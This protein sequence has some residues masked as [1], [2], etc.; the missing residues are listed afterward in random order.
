M[1]VAD[2]VNGAARRLRARQHLSVANAVLDT[3]AIVPTEDRLVIF[4][5]I[6]TAVLLPYLVAVKSLY[7]QIGRGRIILLDDG[8][9]TADDKTILAHHCGNPH[10]VS[11][12]DVSTA[13]CP[14]G[15]CWER[16]LAILDQ[17][18]AD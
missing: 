4:S 11:L 12:D 7:R 2:I 17:R 3:P 5:M 6:G 9:L 1:W 15:N 8:T 16:L 10:I 18:G 14:Q 13:P